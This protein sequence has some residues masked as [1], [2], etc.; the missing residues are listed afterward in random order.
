MI[1]FKTKSGSTF[2][3][4]PDSKKLRRLSTRVAGGRLA[5]GEWTDYSWIAYPYKN[6]PLFIHYDD[7]LGVT[8]S[9][10]VSDQATSTY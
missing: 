4:D 8:S 7:G 10:V 5:S 9:N 3:V 6:G 1:P 2:E